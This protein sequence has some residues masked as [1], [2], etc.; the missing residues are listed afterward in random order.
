MESGQHTRVLRFLAVKYTSCL[1]SKVYRLYQAFDPWL[2]YY[3]KTLRLD[4]IQSS[5]KQYRAHFS[6][7][8]EC[9]AGHI[10]KIT[11]SLFVYF[12]LALK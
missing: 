2:T 10:I 12:F 7:H 1:I 9:D 11:G 5:T 4:L 3:Y 8:F 6:R